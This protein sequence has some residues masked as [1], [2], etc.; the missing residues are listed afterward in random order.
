MGIRN[1]TTIYI[2]TVYLENKVPVGVVPALC[3]CIS[4]VTARQCFAEDLSHSVK[5]ALPRVQTPGWYSRDN[6]HNLRTHCVTSLTFAVTVT[7]CTT[8]T[9]H[10]HNVYCKALCI[11]CVVCKVLQYL[12]KVLLWISF[13]ASFILFVS[14]C[15][16]FIGGSILRLKRF[17]NVIKAIISSRKETCPLSCWIIIQ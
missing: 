9:L 4:R 6:F 11:N 1:S 5:F 10:K 8:H 13:K 16:M 7:F 12:N 17:Q 14:C 3:S 2:Y 15:W